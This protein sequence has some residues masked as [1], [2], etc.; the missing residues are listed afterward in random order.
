MAGTDAADAALGAPP[1]TSWTA[2]IPLAFDHRDLVTQAVARVLRA[3][4][5]VHEALTTAFVARSVRPR[6]R[7]CAVYDADLGAAATSRFDVRELPPLARA[8]STRR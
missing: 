7:R 3:Q 2:P 4:F 8:C 5:A 1:S 6:L